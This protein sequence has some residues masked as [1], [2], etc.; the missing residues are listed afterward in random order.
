MP[1]G[2]SFAC[3]SA[4]SRTSAGGGRCSTTCARKIPPSEASSSPSSAARASP[5]STSRPSP[6]A[7]ATMSA[8]A[9][10][11]RASIPASRELALDPPEVPE[12]RVDLPEELVDELERRVVE[13]ALV[14]RERLD[15]PAHQLPQ[16]LLDR[17]ED[18]SPQAWPP[19]ERPLRRH[20]PEALGDAAEARA[21]D[22]AV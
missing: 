13:G 5:C 21:D 19:L 10:I 7:N 8:S 20:R 17:H 12:Q 14:G 4:S 1:P 18:R 9:S 15:V 16:D 3:A 22:A 2:R 6:R 11:P